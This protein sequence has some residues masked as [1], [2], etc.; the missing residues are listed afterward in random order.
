MIKLVCFVKRK[1]GM[2]R[3]EFYDHWLNHHGPLIANT[4]ELARHLVRYEQHRRTAYADWMGNE[5]FDGITIQ[6][7]TG[8]EAFEAFI[9]EPTY[10]EVLAPDEERFLDRDG[11]VWMITDEPVVPIAGP[12]GA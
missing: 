9:N 6:W 12:T 1:P 3:E 4:P 5:E 7:M 11:L 2:T 10:L 8:P